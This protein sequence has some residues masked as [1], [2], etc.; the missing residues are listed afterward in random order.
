MG[1]GVNVKLPSAL[2]MSEPTPVIVAVCPALNV[3]P[4]MVNVLSVN[5]LPPE[6]LSLVNNEAV[7]GTSSSV[8][9]ASSAI[10]GCPSNLNTAALEIGISQAI[11]GCLN[12][13]LYRYP[14]IP[15]VMLATVSVAEVAPL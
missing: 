10:T 6:P 8:E 7:S 11:S 4:P 9:K 3:T 12:L 1:S 2:T 13:T 14:F 15:V 5:E